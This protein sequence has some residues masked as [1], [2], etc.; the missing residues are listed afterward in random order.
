M[1][2]FPAGIKIT[3]I[4]HSCFLHI[5]ANP[6]GWVRAAI[7]E[8]AQLRRDALIKEWE[9]RLFNDPSVTELPADA[10]ELCAL[11]MARDD[12]KN[13]SQADA[14]L[15]SP[16]SP[17]RH[18]I[19]KFE[20]T[21]RVGNTVRRLDRNPSDATVTLFP[22]GIDLVDQDC[23]CILA[24]VQDLDDWIIGALMGQVNRGRKTMIK[25]WKP[26]IL[27]DPSVTTMPATEDGLINMIVAR[28]DYQRSN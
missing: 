3:D 26:I 16:K 25:T 9:P 8:K 2:L 27:A 20:G 22:S 24:F 5:E 19:A 17:D 7:T 11:I 6:E 18:N 28:N 12:Y 13:R 21:S 23:H 4:E 15:D 10:Y 14:A 1:I